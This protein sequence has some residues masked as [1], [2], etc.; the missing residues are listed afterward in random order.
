MYRCHVCLLSVVFVAL[1]AGR[2]GA[3]EHAKASSELSPGPSGAPSPPAPDAGGGPAPKV[4]PAPDA[5]PRTY[6]SFA[7][8]GSTGSRGAI[9]CA[10][11]A[12]LSFLSVSG[13]GNGS[14][15]LHH[16]DAPDLSHWRLNFTVASFKTS[17]VWLQPRA[18]AGFAEMAIGEDSPGFEFTGT[19]EARTATSGGEV[20]GSLRALWPLGSGFEAV[21]EVGVS[22]GYFPYAPALQRPQS[23]WLPSAALTLGVGF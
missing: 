17:A 3:E 5:P 13:C 16:E 23:A 14:G 18:Q 2:V 19:N 22:F 15:F 21:G 11:V 9:L 7:V 10:E 1:A 8:G 20:G 12:P 4:R 6:V